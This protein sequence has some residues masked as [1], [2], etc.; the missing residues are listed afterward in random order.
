MKV[1]FNLITHCREGLLSGTEVVSNIQERCVEVRIVAGGNAMFDTVNDYRILCAE[2]AI[3]FLR[4]I[5]S[6]GRYIQRQERIKAMQALE[7]AQRA[8][9]IIKYS[10]M[11]KRDLVRSEYVQELKKCSEQILEALG[12]RDWADKLLER[13]QKN[14]HETVKEMIA[15]IRFCLNILYNLDWRLLSGKD[16]EIAHGV[17]IR[18]GKVL[19]VTRHPNANNLLVCRVDVGG[20]YITVVTN[21][22]TIRK[23]DSVAVALLPPKNLRGIISEGMFLGSSEGVLKNVRGN[24][25]EWA[26]VPEDALKEARNF[27]NEFLKSK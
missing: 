11:E 10:Y 19:S 6:S 1:I 12:G 21:D 16:G 5:F 24:P 27:I 13:S 20:A 14:A 8:L 2:K 26:E 3:E 15:Q 22:L 9:M 25:G 4:K 18:V 7:S 23:K 17:D